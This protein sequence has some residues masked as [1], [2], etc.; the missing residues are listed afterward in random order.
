MKTLKN[1]WAWLIL[2]K[3]KL[4]IYNDKDLIDPIAALLKFDREEISRARYHAE[5]KIELNIH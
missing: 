3:V 4:E 2:P 5:Q 1:S